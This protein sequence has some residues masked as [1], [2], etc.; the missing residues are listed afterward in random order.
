MEDITVTE[1]KAR[2]DK[3]DKPVIIDV[4]ENWEY[5]EFNIGA[6]NIPLGTLPEAMLDFMDL[7][8]K[9]IIVHCRSGA[10]SATAKAYLL[11][12]GFTKVRNL[13]GGMMELQDKIK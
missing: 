4:R 5:E 2:M 3:G 9:E 6:R 10:R 8:N 7:K 11:Q 1:L 12:N 13:I